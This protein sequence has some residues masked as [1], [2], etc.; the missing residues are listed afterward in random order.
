[1]MHNT[2]TTNKFI[3]FDKWFRALK[4]MARDHYGFEISA[5]SAAAWEEYY[6]DGFTPRDALDSDTFAG[7]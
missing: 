5:N 7:I 1:M 2:P 6:D 3:E 4:R